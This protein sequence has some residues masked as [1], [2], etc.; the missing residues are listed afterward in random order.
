MSFVSTQPNTNYTVVTDEE[1]ADGTGSRYMLVQN[2]STSGFEV[3]LYGGYGPSGDQK[4]IM[5]YAPD[6]EVA[7]GDGAASLT[8]TTVNNAGS[9]LTAWGQ[10]NAAD[11][12]VSSGDVTVQ[13]PSASSTTGQIFTIKHSA[14]SLLSNTLKITSAGGLIDGLTEATITAEKS[15]TRVSS[16]GSNWKVI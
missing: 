15:S 10:S 4:I 13:L 5:V 9:P 1:F 2:K 8:W 3:D 12:D 14:G 11:V 16:D 6:P 7:V